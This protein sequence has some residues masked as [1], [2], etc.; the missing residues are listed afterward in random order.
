MV[1]TRG[2]KAL[3][4]EDRKPP[5]ATLKINTVILPFVQEL[6]GNLKKG[7]IT[8]E[9]IQQLF[10]V[11][12]GK[13]TDDEVRLKLV[14]KYDREHL[15]AVRLEGQNKSL[16]STV[17]SLKAQVRKLESKEHDCQVLT[18]SGRRCSRPAR[19]KAQ[20]NGIEINVCLQHNKQVT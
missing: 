18:Q 9:I 15:K 3:A 16:Q 7:D 13:V 12:Q 17:R 20:W 1:E 11:L 6:K 4:P 2:R 19:V 8:A 5:Q 14:Q 10:A